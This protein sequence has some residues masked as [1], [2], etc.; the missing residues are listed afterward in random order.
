[1]KIPIIWARLSTRSMLAFLVIA[2]TLGCTRLT[3]QERAHYA[4]RLYN[5]PHERVFEAVKARVTQ[6]PMGLQE[7]DPQ[8]GRVISRI[9]GTTPGIG[10]TVGYQI[11]VMVTAEGQRTR[12]IPSWQMNISS[13]PTKTHLLPVT[14]DDRPLLYWEFFDPLDEQLQKV[15]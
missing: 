7:A 15:Q 1:M 12:V 6:Y 4:S 14:I 11:T 3:P 10:A 2:F 13:E 8:N 9:G 5:I